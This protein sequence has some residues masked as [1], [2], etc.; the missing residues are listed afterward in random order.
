MA[1]SF[2]FIVVG[3]G[4]AGINAAL[5]LQNAGREV[6]IIDANDRPGGR[7][8]TDKVDGF[9][10]DRGFQLI[11]ARY[12]SLAELNVIEEI[13]FIQAPRIIE[14]VIGDD[15]H[16]IG[17][18]RI[19]PLSVLNKA[20]GSIPEKIALLRVLVA[21]AKPEQSIG[22][23]LKST[24]T[25]YERV[26]RPFLQGV[27]LADPDLVDARF[28]LSVLRSFVSGS[29]GLPRNGVGALPEA[30]GKRIRNSMFNTRVDRITGKILE[31]SQGTFT[32]KKIIVA[33]DPTTSAQ[34][35]DLKDGIPMAGCITW[36][37]ATSENPSGNGRLVIDGQ[38]RG[39][40]YNSLVVSD[41]SS[42]YAP[43][44]QH[45]VSS[46][47]GLGAT[48]SDVRRHLSIMWGVDTRDW[49][50]I[51]KY[52]IPGALPLHSIGKSLS[53]QIAISESIF[54]A[55]DHRTVPSQQGALFAGK[56][57]AELAL[58]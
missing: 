39:Q 36:Y 18:P 22:E 4:L 1:E 9:L 33:A 7:I 31:T 55:G 20:T 41:I 40:V 57:A 8:A 49:N 45:L 53:H 44:G 11:N 58:N 25:T 21:K 23:L 16:S 32:A 17:D 24:G 12:P 42:S 2:D 50:L 13:D 38:H 48:E 26:L 51:A 52:E 3:A 37:H 54:L 47:T 43:S 5:T 29:P 6:L 28:G 27:F 15:R 30:L 56:L 35:L 46:T 10:C 19:A 14:V 34:L